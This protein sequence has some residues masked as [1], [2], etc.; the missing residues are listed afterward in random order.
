MQIIITSQP[1]LLV[2]VDEAK[3]ALGESGNDRDA[4]I[5]GLLWAAQGEL[6]GPK[7]WVGVTVAQQGVEARF[8][9]FDDQPIRLPGGPIIGDVLIT[10]LDRS[11]DSQTLD[12]AGYIVATD[13]ALSLAAGASWPY[14]ADQAG[15]CT[16]IY[17]VGMIA[18]EDDPRIQQMKTAII[19]HVRMTLDG[20]DPAASRRAIE[21][22]VRSL[23]VPVL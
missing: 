17:D 11:S 5:E 21:S 4:L 15:V 10:Y 20:V 23:W 13:G 3:V 1:G 22:L 9:S 7:G 14:V 8:D 2:S 19:L 18:G 12:A 6:D 16:A